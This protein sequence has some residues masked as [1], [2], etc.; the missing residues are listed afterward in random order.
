MRK[1]RLIWLNLFLADVNV[2]NSTLC[3][4]L[5]VEIEIKLETGDNIR[6]V[7]EEVRI[8]ANLKSF[9]FAES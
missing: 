6:K 9:S 8:F 2:D 3:V 4:S 1:Y 7:S 5:L